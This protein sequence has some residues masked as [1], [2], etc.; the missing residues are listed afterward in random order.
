V[1]DANARWQTTCDL[2]NDLVDRDE[3]ERLAQLTE[4]GSSDPELRQA[5]ESLLAADESADERLER[6]KTGVADV[7]QRNLAAPPRPP[8]AD[9]LRLVGHTISH[10]QIIE[11]IAAGGMGIVYRA[12]DTSLD[13]DVA[14]K[15]PLVA[16]QLEATGRARFLREAQTA[17]ALDHPNVCSVYEVGESDAGQ[18]FIA[19]ALYAGEALK[20]RIER[21]GPLAVDVAVDIARQVAVGLA[22]A[23][24]SGVVHRDLKPGNVMVLP[25]GTAKILD[26]GLAK[27]T[28][29]SDTASG[30]GALGTAAYMAPEQ[31]RGHAVDAR[32]DL[33]SLGVLLYE[34]LTGNRPFRADDVVAAAHAILH[35]DVPRPSAV[36]PGLARGLDGIVLTLLQKDRGQRYASAHDVASDLE[37][38][39]RGSIPPVRRR[40]PSRA[41]AWLRSRSRRATVALSVLGVTVIASVALAARL[42]APLMKRKPTANAEAYQFYLR[43]REY[44]RTGPNAAADTL[45]RRALAIDSTFALARA[46]LAVV[47][48]SFAN[49][50][51]EARIELGRQEA[52]AALRTQPGL[53]D[54]HYALGL[55]WQRRHDPNRAL[56]EFAIARKG[57]DDSGELDAEIG[58]SYRS[59]GRWNEAITAFER[60][61]SRDPRN[62]VYAPALAHTYGRVRRYRESTRTWS[63]HIALTPDAYNS[64]L[65]KGWAYT[66]WDGTTDTLAAAL[67]R[68]PPELDEAGMATYSKVYV[69]RL[70]RRPSDMLAAL[71]ASRHKVA[72]DENLYSPYSLLRGLAYTD[73]GDSLR[74]RAEFDSAR[75]MMEDSVAVHPSDSRLHIALGMALAGLGRREDA[76]RSAQRAMALAPISAD[77]VRATCFMGS[78]AEIFAFLGEND[79]ALRILDQLLGMPAGREAS[80]PLLR[81]DPAYD[82]IRSDSRFEQMLQRHAAN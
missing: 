34:M 47:H 39:Q 49:R 74:A 43:G 29:S 27:L 28:D 66:R 53:A 48:M 54:A 72:D 41:S 51:D 9:P 42:L 30:I 1:S 65:I 23:H 81:A 38:I 16:Q 24:D 75:V 68:L 69:A 14:L 32:A 3:A 35:D 6:L 82:R 13:R 78:A 15:L 40:I 7:L 76:I 33:W 64:M 56:A 20:A 55:Y 77:I 80:V 8:V 63:R 57:L 79:A 58:T 2:F 45:Y 62:I 19:M 71:N 26:F 59:L 36:R 60:A 52:T 10:F 5:V 18:P 44:E 67:Q 22:F 11:P 46:R 17:G 61:L 21:E 4:I 70:R 12:R 25:D 73:I 50:P 31:V 37:A